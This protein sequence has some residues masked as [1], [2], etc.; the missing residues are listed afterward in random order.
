MDHL[1]NSD[2]QVD[3]LAALFQ[4][5]FAA[6]EGADEGA[7]IAGLVRSICET[8][9]AEDLRSCVTDDG[10]RLIAAALFTR[11]RYDADPR[12]VYLM[13]P[14]AVTPER[15]RQGV[16]TAML[17]HALDGLR[18]DG[19]DIAITYGDPAYYGRVGFRQITTDQAAPPFP[20]QQPHGW[21]GQ[22]LAG[23]GF[24]PVAG[25]SQCVPAF[26]NPAIW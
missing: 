4:D 1:M 2:L 7:L 9:P 24:K 23:D 15:Q 11:L 18:S 19:V 13:S 6:S 17:R 3:A 8:T 20:L 12:R 25:P 10:G 5:S 16:G 26:N 22:D 14:V 21:L